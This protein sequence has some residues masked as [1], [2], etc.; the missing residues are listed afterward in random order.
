MQQNPPAS[1]PEL[2]TV[3][4][5][6]SSD[7]FPMLDRSW[8]IFSAKGI[9]TVFVSIGNSASVVADL[10]I[11]EGL[12]CPINHVALS[13]SEEAAWTEISTILKERKREPTASAFSAAA[14]TKWI[15][16]KNVRPQATLPW[17]SNG[18]VDLSGGAQVKTQSVAD[19]AQ[20]ICTTMKVKDNV[21]RIDILKL[22]TVAA[23]PGLE[24]A[25]L[26][27]VLNAGFRPAVV[28]VHWSERPNVGLA[29]TVAAGNLQNC[30]YRLM[31][32]VDNKFLYYFTDNDMYQLCS[33]EETTCQNPLMQE[34][35]SATKDSLVKNRGASDVPDSSAQLGSGG[36]AGTP[37]SSEKADDRA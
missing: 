12:G 24:R 15:L 4:G 22:D 35:V 30:G 33:W 26:G 23:A 3:I 18:T 13:P 7:P 16:P 27:A 8:D 28:L 37:L 32:T 29:T 19:F 17:W 25:I 6:S 9:R 10:D 14:E 31:S 11:A 1:K 21:V 20:S 5:A 36:K 2:T 34:L